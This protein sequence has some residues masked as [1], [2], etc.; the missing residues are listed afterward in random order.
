LITGSVRFL[1]ELQRLGCRMFLASGTDDGDVKEE[2]RFLGVYDCFELVKGAPAG[3]FG[4]S[5][6]LVMRRLLESA[7][8]NAHMTVFG[9]GRVEIAL[10]R[11]F[12]ATAVGIASDEARRRGI[13]EHKRARL[14]AAGADAIFGD[15]TETDRLVRLV[16]EGIRH[17]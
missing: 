3:S 16:M 7:G 6:E 17:D 5:K 14:E 11:R 9:D 2:A 15:F 13:D 4:C 10:A 8:P 12:G 1:R